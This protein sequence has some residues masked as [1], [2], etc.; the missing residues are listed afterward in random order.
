MKILLDIQSKKHLLLAHLL[1][2]NI[3]RTNNIIESFNSHLQGRLETI[4]GFESFDHANL[5]LNA[6]FLRR[7]FTK[8]T[9][10]EGKFRYLNSKTS[11]QQTP[12]HNV[13]LPTIF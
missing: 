8:F 1:E 2:K 4:K 5:W 3:P 11:V 12:K 9:D 7:R 6:F 10:C 13:D